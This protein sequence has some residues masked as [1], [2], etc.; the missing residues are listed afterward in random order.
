M[1]GNNNMEEQHA[2]PTAALF[3]WLFKAIALILYILSAWFT[4][5]FILI[6]VLVIL[7]LAADFWTVKNVTGRLLVGLRWWNE[8]KED[9]SSLWKFES[10]PDGQ[11]S[12]KKDSRLFWGSLYITPAIWVFLTVAALVKFNLKWLPL[13][14]VAVALN[15]AQLWGYWQ[16]SRDQNK[17]VQTL[18]QQG[19]TKVGMGLMQAKVSS[20]LNS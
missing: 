2:H 11:E 7:M 18:I 13:T 15:G 19:I 4:D 16:C 5:N 6:F 17:N 1:D 14:L 12:N 9:G 10:R 3:T 20:T 8:V